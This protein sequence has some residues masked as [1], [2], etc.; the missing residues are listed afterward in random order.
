MGDELECCGTR[1]FALGDG[2]EHAVEVLS[3]RHGGGELDCIIVGAVDLPVAVQQSCGARPLEH[4]VRGGE[5]VSS[6]RRPSVDRVDEID[7]G[8]VTGEVERPTRRDDD[9]RRTI[10]DQRMSEVSLDS[11]APKLS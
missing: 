4:V 9:D 1:R 5:V 7:D 8:V 2:S 6:E 11:S 3:Q 10:P